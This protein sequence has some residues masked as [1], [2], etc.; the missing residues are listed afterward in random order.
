MNFFTIKSPLL[1]LDGNIVGI[2]GYSAYLS[3]EKDD[4]INDYQKLQ[5]AGVPLR[6]LKAIHAMN[7]QHGSIS[8]HFENKCYL[9]EISSQYSL[10]K[11]E[12]ECLEYYLNGK[13]SKETAAKMG[14]SYRT[15]EEYF[16]N[17]KKK[18]GCRF[19]RDLFEI[20]R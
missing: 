9:P 1:D 17:I 16:T 20:F 6:H 5:N 4:S 2:W 12:R 10:S 13:T 14:L 18:L 3:E 7:N 8:K 11:R 19:K 15:I